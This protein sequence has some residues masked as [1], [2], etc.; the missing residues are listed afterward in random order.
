MA[1]R[2]SR[3]L[4]ESL[5][6]I[7]TSAPERRRPRQPRD[8]Q[9]I[10][11]IK[12]HPV[13]VQAREVRGLGADRAADKVEA[14]VAVAVAVVAE[15]VAAAVVMG[16]DKAAAAVA[17]GGVDTGPKGLLEGADPGVFDLSLVQKII[18]NRK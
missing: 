17:V 16:V 11:G 8:P 18:S 2:I 9:A 6:R 10:P 1:C 12:T 5:L 7:F 3:S 4:W 13:P 15:A 14:V